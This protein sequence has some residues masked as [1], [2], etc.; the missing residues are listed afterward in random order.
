MIDPKPATANAPEGFC[1]ALP[2]DG[3][4]RIVAVPVRE[5]SR[6][7]CFDTLKPSSI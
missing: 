5:A 3:V 6:A 4:V 7:L 2:A 1:E